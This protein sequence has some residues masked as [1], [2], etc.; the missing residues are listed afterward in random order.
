MQVQPGDRLT[1]YLP[2]QTDPPEEQKLAPSIPIAAGGPASDVVDVKVK[3]S[4]M[5]Q[6]ANA[7][8]KRV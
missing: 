2:T 8:A 4:P 6:V 1:I 3:K 5:A 7:T